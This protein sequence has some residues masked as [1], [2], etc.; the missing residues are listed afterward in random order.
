MS[1]LGTPPPSPMADVILSVHHLTKRFEGLVANR[2]ID[3][4]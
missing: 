3:F 1:V 2:E 4:T